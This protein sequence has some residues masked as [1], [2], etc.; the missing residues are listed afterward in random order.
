MGHKYQPASPILNPSHLSWAS[1][2]L[3]A[4]LPAHGEEE[5]GGLNATCFLICCMV[6]NTTQI[7]SYVVCKLLE[8]W[9]P[10]LLDLTHNEGSINVS[11]VS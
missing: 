7:F 4:A 8:R 9:V 5:L 11:C 10:I 2:H 6:V 3:Q 1:R